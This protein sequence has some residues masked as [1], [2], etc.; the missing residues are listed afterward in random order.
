MPSAATAAAAESQLQTMTAPA[1]SGDRVA[2]S[3]LLS[4]AFRASWLTSRVRETSWAGV[5]GVS[6]W[7]GVTGVSGV[8]GVSGWLGCSG[9]SGWLGVTGSVGTS[10]M[11]V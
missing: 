10:V 1:C 11:G 4:P 2:I 6:G 8:S 7:S 9:V 5:S 3:V